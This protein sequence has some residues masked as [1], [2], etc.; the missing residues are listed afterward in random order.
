MCGDLRNSDAEKASGAGQDQTLR[1]QLTYDS[2]SIRAH[3]L[4]YSQFAR[5]HGRAGEQQVREIGA[6]DEQDQAGDG[7]EYAQ[8]SGVLTPETGESATHR[9]KRNMRAP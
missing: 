7:H 2:R 3:G 4:A 1:E 6:G 8:R 9:S 5:T